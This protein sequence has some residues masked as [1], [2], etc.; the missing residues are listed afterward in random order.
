MTGVVLVDDHAVVRAG[1]EQL[2][3]G[4]PGIDIL[5]TAGDGEGALALVAG[6]APDVIL[7]DISMPG[8]DGIE[9]TRRIIA[10]DPAAVVVMLT[11]F[12]D[13][14]RVA[15]ALDAGAV[16]YVLKECE[17]DELI[18]SIHA[19]ARGEAPIAAKVARILLRPP[20]AVAGPVLSPREH[21]VLTLVGDG[22]PNKLIARHLEISEKT[23]KAHLTRI[24]QRIGVTDRT[25]A[26]LWVQ[27]RRGD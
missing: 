22:L 7:M 20:A 21:E 2:L 4:T 24:F 18:R 15:A 26:A 9:A 14:D 12:A 25:A 10:R 5:G 17:P 19:A 6:T 8:V 1:L 16:G 11:S 23:V 3:A 13:D 27:R